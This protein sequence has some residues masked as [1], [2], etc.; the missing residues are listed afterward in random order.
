MVD[1]VCFC[2][3]RTD[4]N[5]RTRSFSPGKG[6]TPP[7]RTKTRTGWQHREEELIR[8]S[9]IN[10]T[11]PGSIVD[12]QAAYSAFSDGGPHSSSGFQEGPAWTSHGPGPPHTQAASQM[13]TQNS[14]EFQHPSAVLPHDPRLGFSPVHFYGQAGPN[15]A[16]P[17]PAMLE[18]VQMTQEG[19]VCRISE[20]YQGSPSIPFGPQPPPGSY[21]MENIPPFLSSPGFMAHGPSTQP[22]LSAMDNSSSTSYVSNPVVNGT[23]YSLASYVTDPGLSDLYLLGSVDDSPPV[24]FASNS[25]DHGSLLSPV[26]STQH[27]GSTFSSVSSSIDSITPAT[28]APSSTDYVSTCLPAQKTIHQDLAL[29]REASQEGTTVDPSSLHQFGASYGTANHPVSPS[30][31]VK[32]R[33]SRCGCASKSTLPSP[34]A[35]ES[36]HSPAKRDTSANSLH[37]CTC[38]TGC[39][40]LFC[41]AH[42]YNST[43]RVHLQGLRHIMD[44]DARDCVDPADL[45]KSQHP[46]SSPPEVHDLVSSTADMTTGML[47]SPAQSVHDGK[48]VPPDPEAKDRSGMPRER[49]ASDYYNFEYHLK[50]AEDPVLVGQQ[51]GSSGCFCADDC[52]CQGCP[53]H[54]N[55]AVYP[56]DPDSTCANTALDEVLDQSIPIDHEDGLDPM[57]AFDELASANWK[58]ER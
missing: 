40:C 37:N 46:L 45:E 52:R 47:P 13:Q 23:A 31:F 34:K 41:A 42:P 8:Q 39:Q 25:M 50:T 48:G 19:M 55:S 7:A 27:N 56:Y 36:D 38:G 32:P 20:G 12:Q 3:P 49:N 30:Q 16:S 24:S 43:S 26:P 53:T 22:A 2:R 10:K 33:R 51:C 18:H 58:E 11:R 1:S 21:F 17:T 28:V 29:S 4:A 15:P 44:E 6:R 35:T 5:G 54:K 9:K 57:F 14:V